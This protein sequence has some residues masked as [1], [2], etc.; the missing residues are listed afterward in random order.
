MDRDGEGRQL[1]LG[2]P[3]PARPAAKRTENESLDPVRVRQLVNAGVWVSDCKG[4]RLRRREV[5]SIVMAHLTGHVSPES[6]LFMRY[7]LE[8]DDPTGEKAVSNILHRPS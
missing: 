2:T 3:P 7:V 8:Y 1:I 4:L 6:E 5:R